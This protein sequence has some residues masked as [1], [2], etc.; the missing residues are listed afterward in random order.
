MALCRG[1]STAAEILAVLLLAPNAPAAENDGYYTSDKKYKEYAARFTTPSNF[2]PDGNSG[3]LVLLI[4]SID[5]GDA[6]VLDKLL[7]AVP[8]FAN[9]VEHGSRSSP[10]HW[11]AY[12]GDTNILGVL[13]KHGA[14][15]N[16]KETNWRITPLHI[17]RNPATVDFLLANGAEIECRGNHGQTPLMWAARRGNVGLAQHLV[18]RGAK[19]ESQ[20]DLGKTAAALAKIWGYTNMVAFLVGKGA[21]PPPEEVKQSGVLEVVGGSF[22]DA[23]GHPFAEA[24][25]IS[26]TR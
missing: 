6:V 25:L 20:D 12:K 13:V 3:Q 19:L 16:T 1:I 10:A 2:Y 18:N 21:T 26:G 5:R 11:A 17:A 14:D 4:M 24:K 23:P 22:S 8:N 9:V 7:T 15:L